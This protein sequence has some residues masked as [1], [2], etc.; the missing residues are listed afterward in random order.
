MKAIRKQK[1]IMAFSQDQAKRAAVIPKNSS[2]S[3]TIEKA[4][5]NGFG[6]RNRGKGTK[7][8]NKVSNG[9]Y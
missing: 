7:P 8:E 6:E 1:A 9:P 5:R 3:V 4:E 2:F